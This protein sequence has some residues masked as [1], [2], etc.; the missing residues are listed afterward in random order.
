MNARSGLWG[1]TVGTVV[2]SVVAA[3]AVTAGLWP[4]MKEERSDSRSGD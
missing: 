4:R 2:L 3:A 1:A